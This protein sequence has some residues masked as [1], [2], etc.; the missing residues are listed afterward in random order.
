MEEPVVEVRRPLICEDS[1]RRKSLAKMES[2]L[3]YRAPLKET[4]GG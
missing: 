2:R 3:R 4:D 1:G